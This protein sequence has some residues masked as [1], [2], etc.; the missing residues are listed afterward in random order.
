MIYLFSLLFA[1]PTLAFDL[2]GRIKLQSPNP[3]PVW[4]E[5]EEKHRP[6][7]GN[8]KLSPKLRLSEEGFVANAVVRLEEM[9]PGPLST[10]PEK[11]Y[12]LDQMGCEFSPHV[13]LIPRG[14]DLSILN[15]DGFLHNV[16]AFD[17]NVE[18]LFNDAMPK[19]GQVLKKRFDRSGRIIIRCGV[20]PWMHAIAIVQEHPFYALT[21]EQG[22]FK[23]TGIP[24]GTYTLSVWHESLGT[25]EAQVEP[26]A[27]F[28]T[29]TYP[30]AD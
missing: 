4:L 6:T 26:E 7:C 8:Q 29:L 27:P 9:P 12:V 16:R 18:M 24:E 5:I 23:I 10:P 19:K 30:A 15:S 2:E 22:Y 1:S 21:D 20:H 14:A 13:V 28:V 11:N 17:E 3:D 25:L